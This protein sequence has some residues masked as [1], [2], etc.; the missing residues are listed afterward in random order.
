MPQT[1]Y[2]ISTGSKAS[3]LHVW[4]R[5]AHS[6]ETHRPNFSATQD[7]KKS[8]FGMLAHKSGHPTIRGAKTK[9]QDIQSWPT[10]NP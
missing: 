4:G 9:V 3:V 1:I 6:T 5:E 2:E 7:Y 10:N 8:F